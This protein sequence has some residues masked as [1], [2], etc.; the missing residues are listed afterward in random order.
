[1]QRDD[2]YRLLDLDG[3][4]AVPP[5]ID[6]L[7]L[8][9]ADLASVPSTN[10][11]AFALDDW[12]LRRGRD[13]LTDSAKM[14]DLHC[15]EHAA[16]DFHAA[17]FEPEPQLQ[18]GCAEHHRWQFLKELLGTPEY[19]ALHAA[20]QLDPVAS[21][22]A[23][24]AFAAQCQELKKEVARPETD[25]ELATLRAIGHAVAKA[26][27]DVDECREAA[28]AAGLGPGS[29]GTNDPTAIANLYRR[30]RQSATLRK[31]VEL[32]G[33]FRRVAQAQQRQKTQHG[34]DDL[35]GVVL[36]GEVG[37]LL[38]HELAKLVLP[39]FEEDLLR[40]LAE[41]QAMCWERCGTEPVAQGPILVVVDESGSMAGT[42][43]HTAKAL[44]LAMAWI[45][46][47]QRRWCSLIAYSGNTGERLLPLPPGRWDEAA[48]LDW[49]EGFLGGGSS[50]DVPIAELPDYYQRLAAP[51]GR[52]D[53]LCVTDAQCR[54]PAEMQTV[55]GAWKQHVQA[56]LITLVLDHKPGDLARVSDELHCLHSL[57][58]TEPA[59]AR[60]LS[61]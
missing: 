23:A 48:L 17:A 33:R 36:D 24:E 7:I 27:A 5:T 3:H 55:F 34:L 16:A 15:D 54:L 40:R 25:A 12:A 61:L 14:Q 53:I 18:D 44:A 9:E 13:L 51:R 1:V 59:V 10:L 38:P 21:A 6:P 57:D 60:T 56:R 4:E 46:R 22:L 47:Q 35:V 30:V 41:R 39:E 52:T 31:I 42:K 29:P 11:T 8:P 43:V 32:A 58:V 26:A 45:A 50:R 37:R 49:L 2:L 19:L 20:T 28:L